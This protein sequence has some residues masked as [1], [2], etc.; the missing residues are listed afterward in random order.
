MLFFTAIEYGKTQ[1]RFFLALWTLKPR[2]KLNWQKKKFA[3]TCT[4]QKLIEALGFTGCEKFDNSFN[5]KILG[6]V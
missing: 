2:K 1:T 5:F 4:F 3:L 6:I